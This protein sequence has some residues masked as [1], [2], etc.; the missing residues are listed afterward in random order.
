MAGGLSNIRY[1]RSTSAGL[2]GFRV[3]GREE[4][5]SPTI[6]I[7][8][9]PAQPAAVS[10]A[11]ERKPAIVAAEREE[12]VFQKE[13]YLPDR[14]KEAAFEPT[15][16]AAAYAGIPWV[17]SFTGDDVPIEMTAEVQDAYY[18]ALHPIIQT[19]RQPGLMRKSIDQQ[20]LEGM[21]RLKREDLL[22]QIAGEENLRQADL[23]DE[24]EARMRQIEDYYTLAM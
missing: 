23:A 7:Y 16:S 2:P 22:D 5:E 4:P 24:R 15:I 6:P 8:K 14:G 20:L 12:G 10:A 17:D 1:N 21:Q 11:V 19:E 13:V 3:Y 18:G 9:G